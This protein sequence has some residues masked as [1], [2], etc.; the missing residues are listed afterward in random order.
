RTI[1]IFVTFVNR[2]FSCVLCRL[3]RQVDD[4]PDGLC[5]A[6]NE[7]NTNDLPNTVS[8]YKKFTSANGCRTTPLKK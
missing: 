2:T 8:I 4:L 7:Q 1:Y 3:K 5:H 6:T